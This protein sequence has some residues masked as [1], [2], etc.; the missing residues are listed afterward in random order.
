MNGVIC[1]ASLWSSLE[2]VYTDS[3]LEEIFSTEGA[4]EHN[5]ILRARA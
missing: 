1:K 4:L 2:S 5:V 3:L